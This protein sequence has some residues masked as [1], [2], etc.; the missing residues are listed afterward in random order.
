[1]GLKYALVLA[2][3]AGL[4]EVVPIVGPYL[5][6]VPAVLVALTQDVRLA[7]VVSVYIVVIQLV[8]GYVLVPR[9]MAKTVGVSPLTVVLG[10][11]VGATL[12]G[13]S[14]ALVAVPVAAA[15]QVILQHLL[16]PDEEPAAEVQDSGRADPAAAAAPGRS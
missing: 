15:L 16:A 1:M 9:V 10:L 13:L 3:I 14:G 12:G 4:L 11:L 5:G 2:L 6:A 8:E 7:L